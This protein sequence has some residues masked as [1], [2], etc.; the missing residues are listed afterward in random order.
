MTFWL[1]PTVTSQ[2]IRLSTNFHDL[3][4]ELDLHLIMIGFHG[5]F[6]TG[7][8]Y[9]QGTLTLPDTW[10]RPS[11]LGLACAPIVETR[12]LELALSLLDLSPWIPLC[13]FS[14][15]YSG[16]KLFITFYHINFPQYFPKFD[17]SDTLARC[18]SHVKYLIFFI[19]PTSPIQFHF[20]TKSPNA[21]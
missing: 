20:L 11:F 16:A 3:D 9:Q 10:F 14:I 2:L 21:T 13:T 12:F 18:K 1:W 8:A 6:A 7:V 19:T 5:S 15:P 4:T 17:C